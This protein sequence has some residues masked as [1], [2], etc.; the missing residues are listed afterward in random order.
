MKIRCF[1]I[2][3]DAAK[4]FLIWYTLCINFVF[5][6]EPHDLWGWSDS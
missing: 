2:L 6:I 3:Y 1:K 5:S 4:I